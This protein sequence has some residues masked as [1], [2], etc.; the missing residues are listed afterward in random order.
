MAGGGSSTSHHP[1]KIC[2]FVLL[3]WVKLWSDGVSE[4][5]HR[6]GRGS[7]SERKEGVVQKMERVEGRGTARSQVREA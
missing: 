6:P 3:N 4:G 1:A 5:L 7:S 2:I